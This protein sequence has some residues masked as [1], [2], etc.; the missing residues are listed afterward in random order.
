MVDERLVDAPDSPAEALRALP[1]GVY[2]TVLID[3]GRAEAW[4][5]HIAR[6]SRSF[7]YQQQQQQQTA[8]GCAVARTAVAPSN[9]R[10]CRHLGAKLQEL[11]APCLALALSAARE[12]GN[13]QLE[14][15]GARQMATILLCPPTV[16]RYGS[17]ST[18]DCLR[19]YQEPI[20]A[21]SDPTPCVTCALACAAATRTSSDRR[22]ACTSCHCQPT[23][24]AHPALWR[25]WVL[26]AAIRTSSARCGRQRGALHKVL[27]L[28]L[29][30]APLLSRH[31]RNVVS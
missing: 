3:S 4:E 15:S 11:I 24:F 30:P 31:G 13:A 7:G 10:Q 8:R 27:S 26:H 17:A 22:S 16:S 23:R 18:V 29:T 1:S 9:V 2:T 25:W 14:A 6:L 12:D 21:L 28:E 19:S 5:D 20:E